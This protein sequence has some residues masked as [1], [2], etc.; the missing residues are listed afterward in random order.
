M[1]DDASE[2]RGKS[3]GW[4]VKLALFTAGLI[5]GAMLATVYLQSQ[6]RNHEVVLSGDDIT[7]RGGQSIIL[8][9][10]AEIY[11]QNCM[12]ACDQ[13]SMEIW[14]NNQEFRI[15][16]RDRTGGCVL[17]EP[18]YADTGSRHKVGGAEKLGVTYEGG[19]T[20]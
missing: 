7:R 13:V 1:S 14:P 16:V 3:R 11:R 10:P 4:G 18:V 19:S 17:C 2:Q 8:K 6:P 5:G 15:E 20:Y 12:G 9:S